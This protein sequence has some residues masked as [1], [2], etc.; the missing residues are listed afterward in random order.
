M[1]AR[2]KYLDTTGLVDLIEEV[3]LRT[4]AR[5]NYV[6]PEGR[7]SSWHPIILDEMER[8]DVDLAV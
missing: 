1:S 5:L 7:D 2:D 3:R 8:K 6:A 4:W